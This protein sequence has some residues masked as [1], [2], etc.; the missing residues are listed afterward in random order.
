M[1]RLPTAEPAE[2]MLAALGNA[3]DQV[4]CGVALLDRDMRPR[5]LNRKFAEL[6]ADASIR[7]DLVA[8]IERCDP[9][10]LIVLEVPGGRQLQIGCIGVADGGHVL[11]S[12]GIVASP[13]AETMRQ[14]AHDEAEQLSAELRFNKEVLEDQANYLASLAEESVAN[15]QRAEEARCQLEHEIAERRLLEEELRRLATT[16]ALTGLLNRRRFFELA[17]Q[18]L[19]R[20]GEFGQRLAVLM[21]D[22]DHFKSINDRYGHPVGDLALRQV[23]G[24]LGAGV[25]RQDLVGRLG[26]EEF[27]VVVP[28][29][30]PEDGWDIAER[31]RASIA[32]N[33]LAHGAARIDI[34][35][36]IGLAMADDADDSIERVVGRADALLYRAKQTGRNRTCHGESLVPA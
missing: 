20:G 29:V 11:A 27:A 1:P 35:V 34:T 23:A 6:W 25:R 21:I 30:T 17:Q 36:S 19:A 28:A 5:L 13:T 7:V 16:D 9:D 18:E 31:L 15:A 2:T 4:D 10:T 32:A 3:L 14:A 8:G 12:R 26:G 33:Q 22:I 24:L